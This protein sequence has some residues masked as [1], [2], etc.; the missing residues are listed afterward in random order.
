[1]IRS[2][3]VDDEQIGRELLAELLARHCPN[4]S[5]LAQADSVARA[6]EAIER[7]RPDLVFLDI[8][9][10]VSN[11]FQLLEDRPEA[12]FEVVFTTAFEQ[13]AVRAI[14]ASA[15]DY[16]LKPINRDELIAAVERAERKLNAVPG[17]GPNLETLLETLRRPNAEP[18]KLALPTEEGLILVRLADVVRCEAEGS[19]TWFHLVG[20]GRRLVSRP[21]KEFDLLLADM[22]FMRVHHSH[23][24]NI[25]HIA[26][27]VRGEG[28]EVVMSDGSTV[29]VARRK[30][31]ELMRLLGAAAHMPRHR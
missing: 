2:I 19:Y 10:P 20:G 25:D 28:G 8:Q 26:R 14:K 9:M 27:Y 30:K 1:M 18:S 22:N 23:M 29:M 13:Y 24:V 12:A 5:V 4:V 15:L 17:F 16:L 31:E 3:I 7:H 21:L 6:R 11:G